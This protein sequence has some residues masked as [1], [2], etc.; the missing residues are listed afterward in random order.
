[1]QSAM[2]LPDDEKLCGIRFFHEMLDGEKKYQIN[3]R[4][5]TLPRTYINRT[6]LSYVRFAGTDLSQSFMCWNDFENCDF[7]SADLSGCDMRA[8]LFA[9][10]KFRDANLRGADF[11]WSKLTGCDFTDAD[12]TGTIFD[13]NST[14]KPLWNKLSEAQR[15]V[16]TWEPHSGPEPP[17]G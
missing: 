8:S 6:G 3:L 2:P 4:N 13:D 10:C 16:I 17:G 5:L 12:M 11:R 1:M 14:Y 15:K 9:K 7:T